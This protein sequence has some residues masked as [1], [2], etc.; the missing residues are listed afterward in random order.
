[1]NSTPIKETNSSDVI[2]NELIALI[3]KLPESL[4]TNLLKNLNEKVKNII[5]TR[6]FI[7]F[8]DI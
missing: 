3:K 8:S 6:D 1:L 5:R 4:K 7:L 2:V